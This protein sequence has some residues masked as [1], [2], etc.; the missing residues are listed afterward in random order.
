MVTMVVTFMATVFLSQHSIAQSWHPFGVVQ[1]SP[2][3]VESVSPNRAE[4]PA[5]GLSSD[6]YLMVYTQ[7]SC[8]PCRTWKANERP[9][10]QIPITTIDVVARPDLARKAGVTTTPSFHLASKAT[11]K[12]KHRWVG[13]TK[14]SRIHEVAKQKQ[15][16]P[17][18]QPVGRPTGTSFSTA[19]PAGF[20]TYNGGGHWSVDGARN[21][22]KPTWQETVNHLQ[23]H[24]YTGLEN[25][26]LEQLLSLHD[27][28]H[29]AESRRWVFGR[30][31]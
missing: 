7:S 23:S 18:C 24:G 6:W 27:Q 28:T 20:Y 2:V 9:K 15:T 14:A 8:G 4:T 21:P 19:K 16:T 10:V 13:Y 11:Q 12:V 17:R 3:A 26:S 29:Q 5:T 30:I 31:K 22:W 25:R 1:S